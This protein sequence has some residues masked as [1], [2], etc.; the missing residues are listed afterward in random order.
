ML[1]LRDVVKH[2]RSGGRDRCGPSTASRSRSS[3]ASSSR[4][5]ARAA[6]A[7]RRCC[8]SPRGSCAP[9]ARHRPLRRPRRLR[10]SRRAAA[11]A[12]PAPRRR[13]RLPVVPPDAPASG[14]RQRGGQAA[15]P[16]ACSL[17]AARR[18]GEP[19][20][21]R[22]GLGHRAGP[23][24]GDS[25]PAGERQ[26]VA[27][28]RALANE[29]R[30]VL[31]DEPTGNLDTQR[32]ARGARA[33][34]RPQPA[35]AMPARCWSR[36]TRRPTKFADRVR[37]AARRPARSHA[38]DQPLR[39]W[40]RRPHRE[41]RASDLGR[42]GLRP[43]AL[44]RFYR[45]AP[46]QAPDAGAA[47]RASASRSASRSCSP[48]WS[49]TPASPDRPT[50]SCAASSGDARAPAAARARAT[51][52]TQRL[53]ER[54][55]RLPGVRHAPRRCC[56]RVRRVAGP[57]GRRSIELMGATPELARAR[58]RA[59]A[60][61]RQPRPAAVERRCPAGR[62]S[63]HAIGA[64][65]G[66][67]ASRLCLERPRAARCAVGAVLGARR[68]ARWRSSPSAIAPLRSPSGSPACPGG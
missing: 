11:A 44:L 12:L 60:Q 16:T 18:A 52:S 54:V 48:C 30:P 43:R 15:R 58:R 67:R 59:D 37:D 45:L 10:L 1:E 51:A 42:V 49:R 32:G 19:W 53:A 63:A 34:A 6:P 14:A 62:A 35:S 61:L 27:I 3:P 9:D 50:R 2:Y 20:L 47:A 41:S 40:S 26:R 65:A 4:S 64:R 57:S 23:H 25:C 33:A 29:P 31:A 39:R 8:C 21:E 68:S 13:L 22:V 56:A 7:R 5:T 46:A 24:A 28:A 55:A 66:R 36:T 38:L 17:A